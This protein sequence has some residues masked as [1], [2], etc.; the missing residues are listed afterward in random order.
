M[1]L[2]PNLD[3]SVLRRLLV[4]ARDLL[5]ATDLP[6]ISKLIGGVLHE[7]ILMDG[8]FLNFSFGKTECL[9]QFDQK[10]RFKKESPDCALYRSI[11]N[12]IKESQPVDS[13]STIKI[14]LKNNDTCLLN[15]AKS[16]MSISFPP[17]KP[18]GAL[19][20]FWNAQQTESL[21]MRHAP[22]AQHIIELA[23]ASLGNL[24]SR[25]ELESEI[26]SQA[27][28]LIEV[29]HE[30]AREIKK[31]DDIEEETQRIAITDVLTGLLNRRGFFLRAEQN[32]KVLQRQGL[33]GALVF[34]DI[35]GLKTINDTLGH[36]SG[37]SLIKNSAKILYDSFRDSDVV[38]RLGG[39]EF[40]ALT[41]D[42]SDPEIIVDRIQKKVTAFNLR[43][44]FP[45]QVSLSIGVVQ[46]N[47]SSNIGLSD[48]L[49]IAD[50]R[51]YTEK[52]RQGR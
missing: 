6:S 45:Y 18:S 25:Q 2:R 44:S 31:R 13:M 28:E 5:Q 15:E 50:E 49:S 32:F 51:M 8:A 29:V 38:A 1:F 33:A 14:N 16:C 37:D 23:Y 52:K 17:V 9:M 24:R 20:L 22:I 10:G 30:H 4:F 12:T 19:I 3:I 27:E 11:Q 43:S 26:V 7:L 40:A 48:Y 21:I 39:D 42:V 47:L 35:D 36:D 41:F 34:I 46:C